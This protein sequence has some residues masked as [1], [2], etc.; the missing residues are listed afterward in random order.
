MEG[1]FLSDVDI[2]TLQASALQA[3][4]DGVGVVFLTDGP[5]GDAIVLAAGLAARM[6]TEPLARPAV[7]V[8]DLFFGVRQRLG[9]V[10][11]RHPTVLAREMTTLDHVTGGQAMLAFMGPFSPSVSAATAEAVAL[12]RDMWRKGIGV[13]GGP[14]YPAAG[15]VNRP[16]PQRPGGPPIAFDLTDGSA[17]DRALLGACDFVLVPV[18]AEPPDAL[19]PG[20]DVC[21]IRGGDTT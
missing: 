11:H 2:D 4:D 1:L 5:L 9:P 19:P 14:Q 21:W 8:P 12:C 17:P 7:G 3:L 18:G 6:A 13:S 20:V 10:P 15:A 16:L